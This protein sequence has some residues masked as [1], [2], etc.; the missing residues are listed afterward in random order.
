[1]T[2]QGG[3]IITFYSYKGGTG[4]TMALANTAWILASNGKRVLTVDWDLEAP[5]LH[6]FFS[7][8]LDPNALA[9][10]SGVIDIITEYCWAAT[11]GGPRSGPW[12]LDYARVEDHAVSL[13]TEQHGLSF[14]HE[15]SLDFLSA[16]RQ[17]REYTA[18]VSS[19]EWDNFYERLGGGLFLDALRDDMRAKYDYVLIDSRTGLTD[20]ADIC[21]I[22]MPDVVVTCFTLSGQALDGAAAVA[23]NVEE[24][25]RKRRIRVLPVPMRVDEGEKQKV[26]AGRALARLQFEGL[27]KTLS[28][29]NR[30]PE[31]L[32]AYWGAVEIPYRPFYAYEETLATV[33][34][35]SGMPNSMLSAFERLTAEITNGEVTHLPPIPEPVR[36]RC[37]D[38]F[39]RRTPRPTRPDILV[40]YAAENRLWAEWAESAFRRAGCNVT[41]HDVTSHAPT[42]PAAG[43]RA[44][45]LLSVPFVSARHAYATWR[46][47][48]EVTSDQAHAPGVAFRVDDVRLSGAYRSSTPTPTLHGLDETQCIAALLGALGLQAETLAS[49]PMDPSFPGRTPRL[50]NVPARNTT[51]TGRA[52]VLDRLRD[53]LRENMTAPLPKPQA[54][55]G[56]GG[57]GKTQVALEYVHRFMADY[58]LIWWI[59]AEETENVVASLAELGARMGAQGGNDITLVSQE[60]VHL[61]SRDVTTKRWLL[62]FDNADDPTALARFIPEGGSGHI[63]VTS[64]NQTWAEQGQPL[65]VAVF[66]R[67]E[68]VEHLSRRAPGLSAQEADRVAEAVGD[69][70]LAVEQAAAWL[71][72]TATPVEEY[73]RLL[74]E[75]TSNVLNLNQAADYPHTV[76]AT[77]LV[78]IARLQ[79]RSPASVRLLQVC[80]FMGPEP[81]SSALL[82]SKE[83]LDELKSVDPT[84]Q[85]RMML[86]LVVREISRLALAQV[87]QVNNSIQ[88]HRLVQAVIRSQ[89]STEEQRQARHVVHLVL[90]GARPQDD[91]PTDNPEGWPRLEI[92]WPH[93]QASNAWE[94][95]ESEPRRLLIDRVRYLWKRGGFTAAAQLAEEI[96]QHWKPTLGE[97]H[98]QYLYLRA[99]LAN[100]RRS[101]G[102]YMEAREIDEDVLGRQRRVLGRT[103]PHTYMTMS[104][105][106]GD[107]A[108]LGEYRS[109]V[110]QAREAYDGYGQIFHDSHPRTLN[111]ANN[112][113]LALRMVGRYGEARDI[114][115][116]TYDRRKEVLG[117]YHPYTLSSASSL[118]RD[119]REVGRYTDSVRL[120]EEAYAS[121]KD[122]LTKSFPG[123]LSCAKALAVSL[124]RAGRFEEAERLTTATQAEYRAQY[125]APTPDS[126]A[127]DLNWAADLYATGKSEEARREA[128]LALTEYMKVPGERHPYTLAALNNLAIYQWSCGEREAESAFRRAHEFMADVLGQR[129]PHT[130]LCRAN[131]ANVRAEQGHLEEARLVEEAAFDDLRQVLGVHHPETLAVGSNLAL[132]LHTLGRTVEAEQMTMEV[133]TALGQQTAVLGHNNPILQQVSQKQRVYRDLEPLAV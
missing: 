116:D 121:H 86:G 55:F 50:W 35:K 10:T 103:H 95:R 110:E 68:S 5:G 32:D 67:E 74:S 72:E 129:H 90:A 49:G 73:L 102:R 118:G 37:L 64:R 44:V 133:L 19:F 6:R 12:H 80:A 26:E 53:Q 111:A 42:Q 13:T 63:L 60:A 123:T 109:A 120:L 61:L 59:S 100:V 91:E 31:Q 41:L 33:G 58:D 27:P 24:G 46:L 107:L 28:G 92:I 115:Q 106:S 52:L 84:L 9:A 98:M 56:L 8:F 112:L 54:L 122:T 96:L 1:M 22:Q 97:D 105:L 4:R 51:F 25:Y 117:P 87:D 85:E 70:P 30:T 89:L 38:A 108:A 17:N 94:C 29:E 128:H 78:S 79:D 113:A 81:I 93:L 127:C 66:T 83:M 119:L 45:V 36:S 7:P 126:L 11:T 18:T 71:A 16:G 114:D 82:Y 125:D 20:N 47:L 99:Q 48:T 132:T 14:P 76:A 65:P 62:V 23:R 75:Q 34:D 101:Q 57:V 43:T 69:L 131:H 104:G 40:V 130:L 88:I 124:R 77:W 3:R 21:T 15:G 2:A 39:T